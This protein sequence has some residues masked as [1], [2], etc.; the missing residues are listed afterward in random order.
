MRAVDVNVL[1]IAAD[2][3]APNNDQAYELL[4]KLAV[5]SRGL[6]LFS[7]VITG[8]LR[9]ATDRRIYTKPK[10]PAAA[11]TFI[12]GLLQSPTTTVINPS[13]RHWQI[14]HDLI[15]EHRPR[16]SDITDYWLAAAAIETNAEW[17]SY[18]RGFAKFKNLRW[19]HPADLE[20]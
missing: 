17:V 10:E 2:R 20:L 13:Q 15:A 11:L 1:L 14:F 9:I 4:R 16:G 5:D 7:T 8:F 3:G 19:I 18:D 6:G 12:D